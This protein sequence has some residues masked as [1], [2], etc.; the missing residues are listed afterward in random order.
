M[1]DLVLSVLEKIINTYLQLDI[2]ILDLIK[3]IDGKIIKVNI[4]D[5]FFII[6]I[7]A[8]A[9]RLQLLSNYEGNPDT[10]IT[11][12]FFDL[13]K[14]GREK[15][16]QQALFKYEIEIDGDIEVGETIKKILFS[17]NIDW[18]EQLSR[19][20]GDI[21]AHKMGAKFRHT[22]SVGKQAMHTLRKNIT[23]FLQKETDTLPTQIEVE[24]FIC[25]VSE[26]QNDI[27]RLQAR[28]QRLMSR[29]KDIS[30]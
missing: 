3:N 7:A 11:G 17:M 14:I 21:L 4:K 16:T 30:L 26:L 18:E 23:N 8:H 20:I 22:K 2:E 15:G 10:S 13:L 27:N 6:F 25:D 1:K 19:L 28:L 9:D 29:N 24:T 5:W 12:N